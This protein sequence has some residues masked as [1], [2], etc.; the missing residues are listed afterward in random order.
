[1][2]HFTASP[3]T[4][5]KSQ[6]LTRPVAITVIT[7]ANPDN[8]HTTLATSPSL[9]FTAVS[10]P[11]PFSLLHYVSFKSKLTSAASSPNPSVRVA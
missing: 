1:L 3:L 2:P 5:P 9:S 6:I 11:P 4:L 8:P 10:S 7:R